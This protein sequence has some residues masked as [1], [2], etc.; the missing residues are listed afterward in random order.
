MKGKQIKRIGN[1]HSGWWLLIPQLAEPQE[2]TYDNGWPTNIIID[3]G[4]EFCADPDYAKYA[5]YLN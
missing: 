3:W 4:E 2:D 5:P 1:N